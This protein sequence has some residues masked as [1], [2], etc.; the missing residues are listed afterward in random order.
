[1]VLVMIRKPPLII[2]MFYLAITLIGVS[3]FSTTGTFHL[4]Q[5]DG[6]L[7]NSKGLLHS[8]NHNIDFLAESTATVRGGRNLSSSMRSWWLRMIMP[9]NAQKTET[10]VTAASLQTVNEYYIPIPKNTILINLRI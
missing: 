9:S 4:F 6:G 3:A 5:N 8:I 2:L 7:T 1:M 10:V